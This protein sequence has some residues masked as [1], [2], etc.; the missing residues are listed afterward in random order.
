MLCYFA[1]FHRE[2][3]NQAKAKALVK[4]LTSRPVL[5]MALHLTDLLKV[6]SQLS[7]QLQATEAGVYAFHQQLES[8]IAT[9]KKLKDRYD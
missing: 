3:S 8:L 4:L 7:E 9:I 2:R 6:L 5:L 1:G